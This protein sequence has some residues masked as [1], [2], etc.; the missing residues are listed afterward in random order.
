MDPLSLVERRLKRNVK[1][2]VN[3]E[4]S[5]ECWDFAMEDCEIVPEWWFEPRILKPL[6]M[7][8]IIGNWNALIEDVVNALH[9]KERSKGVFELSSEEKELL[10]S[11]IKRHVSRA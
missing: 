11:V 7:S 8:G 4:R 3:G 9:I 6:A 1:L 2:I 10:W 5:I